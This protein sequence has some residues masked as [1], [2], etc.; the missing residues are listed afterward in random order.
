MAGQLKGQSMWLLMLVV[1]GILVF[2]TVGAMSRFF[3][4]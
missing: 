3:K 4:K 2:L 1:G